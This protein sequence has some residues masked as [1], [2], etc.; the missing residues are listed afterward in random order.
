[1]IPS[2]E[3]W[4]TKAKETP[5]PHEVKM[6][7]LDTQ[8]FKVSGVTLMR[9]KSGQT[10]SSKNILKHSKPKI[11]F[12]EKLLAQQN[13]IK[14]SSKQKKYFH[15]KKCYKEIREIINSIVMKEF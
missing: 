5:S 7:L 9:C 10:T 6:S 15:G 4:R 13:D 2:L 14:K 1:M 3:G 12:P 11:I 8:Y